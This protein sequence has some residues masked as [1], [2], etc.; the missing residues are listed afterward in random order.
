MRESKVKEADKMGEQA[1]KRNRFQESNL[2]NGFASIIGRRES[3][4]HF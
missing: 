3:H 1:L 2:M 4:L